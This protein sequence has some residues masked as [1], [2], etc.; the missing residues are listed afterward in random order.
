MGGMADNLST[1]SVDNATPVTGTGDNLPG[2]S[3]NQVPSNNTNN[4]SNVDNAVSNTSDTTLRSDGLNRGPT[5]GHDLPSTSTDTLSRTDGPTGSGLDDLG[6]TGDEAAGAGDEVIQT[7]DEVVKTGDE[8]V[9]AE[10]KTPPKSPEDDEPLLI[11]QD[12]DFSATHN[13]FG[14]RKS[15]FDPDVGIIPANPEGKITPLEHV[16]GGANPAAK[17]SS[18]FTSF[19][20]KDGTG[21]VYGAQ[22]I[23]IDYK[24]LQADIESGKVQG[25]E[26]LRPEQIQRSISEEINKVAGKEVEVPASLKASDT[27]AV[28]QFV[29]SLELSKSKTNKVHRRVMALLN[30]RRDGE[31]LIS[32]IV[33]KEYV[34]GPYPTTKKP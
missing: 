1:N 24:R 15:H 11:R 17:E 12:D 33:P 18:Q 10:D 16:L 23:S 9:K 14:L 2:N 13:K 7:G 31:W 30:T 32:G 20:P 28:T 6:R 8:V 5:G 21:K 27:D 3:G 22:E 34:T 4:V 25:V 19:A 29:K 26:I